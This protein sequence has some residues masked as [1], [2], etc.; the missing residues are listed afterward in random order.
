MG[1][2]TF[3]EGAQPGLT[4]SKYAAVA[5]SGD[6]TGD[7]ISDSL[8]RKTVDNYIS[9]LPASDMDAHGLQMTDTSGKGNHLT[10]SVGGGPIIFTQN[11]PSPVAAACPAS[12]FPHVMHVS[13]GE[14]VTV[15]GNGFSPSPWLTCA[16]SLPMTS[17]GGVTHSKATFVSPFKVGLSK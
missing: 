17:G 1:Y 15:T 4:Y 9:P 6:T 16:F 8:T 12:V 14:T 5:A 11:T 10:G 7:G 2:Y 13:G 3:D